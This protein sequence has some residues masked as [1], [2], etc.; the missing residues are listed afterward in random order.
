MPLRLSEHVLVLN[1]SKIAVLHGNMFDILLVSTRSVLGND[2]SFLA[3][4]R[5]GQDQSRHRRPSLRNDRRSLLDNQMLQH[6]LTDIKIL[7]SSESGSRS[8]R[9]KNVGSTTR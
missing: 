6:R 1:E 4:H 8:P 9:M 7:G 3:N 2:P 5:R